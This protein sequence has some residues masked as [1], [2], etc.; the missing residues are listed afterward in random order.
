MNT[1]ADLFA[2]SIAVRTEPVQQR[3]TERITSLLDAAAALIDQNGI[4]GLTTSDVATR[5][6]SSVGVVYRYFPNIQSRLRALAARNL[7]KFTALVQQAASVGYTEW[8]EG[9]DAVID[10]YVS[11]ARTEPGFRAV[12]FGDIIDE[13]FIAEPSMSTTTSIA[14]VFY[15]RLVEA[16][17]F[18]ESDD[19]KLDVEIIVE[20]ADGILH[21]AFRYDRKGDERFI[22]RLR[23]IA[24]DFLRSYEASRA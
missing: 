24:R 15:G 6:G 20:V 1:K 18:T 17:G 11:L 8:A 19:L 12:R 13:R 5:S 3:S 22:A 14:H 23:T 16:Y 7:E 9:A 2:P 4:D 10:A 21:R